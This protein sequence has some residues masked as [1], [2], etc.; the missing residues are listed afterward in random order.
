MSVEIKKDFW[1]ELSPSGE[2]IHCFAKRKHGKPQIIRTPWGELEK[3][4]IETEK[5]LKEA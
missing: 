2:M 3:V 4:K 1:F 5:K